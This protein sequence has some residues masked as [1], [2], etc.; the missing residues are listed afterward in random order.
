MGID[1]CPMSPPAS[2]ARATSSDSDI[3]VRLPHVREHAAVLH[4]ITNIVNVSGTTLTEAVREKDYSI[5][6]TLVLQARGLK[7]HILF[8]IT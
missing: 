3:K 6:R 5:T 1:D 2:R 8:G 4:S 7:K